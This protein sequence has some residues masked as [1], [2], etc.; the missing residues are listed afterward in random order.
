MKYIT[1]AHIYQKPLKR[2]SSYPGRKTL[3]QT[4]LLSSAVFQTTLKLL[5][6][7]CLKVFP[8]CLPHVSFFHISPPSLFTMQGY[9][10][11]VRSPFPLLECSTTKDILETDPAPN[12]SPDTLYQ[13]SGFQA[14]KLSHMNQSI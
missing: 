1:F 8:K 6:P 14:T 5:L 7:K 13:K 4:P 9:H 10:G 2:S 12:H 11:E 3:L